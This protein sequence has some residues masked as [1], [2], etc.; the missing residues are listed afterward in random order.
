MKLLVFT[1]VIQFLLQQNYTFARHDHPYFTHYHHHHYYQ[2]NEPTDLSLWISEQQVKMFSGYFF[3]IF[4][5][6]NGRV[7][8]L[9]RD[10]AFDTLMPV[11][12]P[13]ISH[14]NFTWTSAKK[15]Y[16]YHFD[17]LISLDEKVLLSPVI[18]IKPKGK[19]PHEPKRKI[20]HLLPYIHL[21]DDCLFNNRI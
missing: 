9:L 8:P 20:I 5:I 7:N 19:I 12:P 2:S 10:P 1:I 15:K 14:M 3:R 11:I 18:S 16:R 6:E 21:I 13:E 17:Q 4:A